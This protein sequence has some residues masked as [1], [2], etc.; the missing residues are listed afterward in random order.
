MKYGRLYFNVLELD[1]PLQSV[2]H[3]AV[4]LQL[5]AYAAGIQRPCMLHHAR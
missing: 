5:L 2:V 4:L 3:P 1:L